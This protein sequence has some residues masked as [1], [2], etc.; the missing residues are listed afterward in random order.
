MPQQNFPIAWDR[1]PEPESEPEPEQGQGVIEVASGAPPQ[2]PEVLT[3]S[4]KP[5]ATRPENAFVRR[6]LLM[7]V[8]LIFILLAACGT[9]WMQVSDPGR[10]M[11][12]GLKAQE[13]AM[14]T[15]EAQ[16]R[17]AKTAVITPAPT[18]IVVEAMPA[19]PTAAA[20]APRVAV[21]QNNVPAQ[22]AGSLTCWA[23]EDLP[24]G[25]GIYPRDSLVRVT[26]W[27]AARGGMVD[28]EG[29]WFSEKQVR[30]NGDVRALERTFMLVP[31]KTPA[32]Y[33]APAAATPV[34]VYVPAPTV[35]PQPTGQQNGITV[36]R[37]G[38]INVHIWGVSEIWIDGKGVS[39][40]TYC[41]VREMKIVV[42]K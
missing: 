22:P 5:L 17:A 27:T 34:I 26:G 15:T 1:N 23:N 2:G 36:E 4:G 8:G 19:P 33:R 11:R 25:L 18:R 7:A 28:I 6:R 39:S 16:T 12:E 35:A 10:S 30:C 38:C 20:T 42:T 31:T 21:T 24:L 14:R 9:I 29:V 40:G 37:S 13:N 41:G 32:P 3:K